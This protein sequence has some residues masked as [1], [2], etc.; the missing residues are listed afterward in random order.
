MLDTTPA[1]WP[2]AL[3]IGAPTA[4]ILSLIT[5]RIYRR[6][7]MRRMA[8]A[9]GKPSTIA[10]DASLPAEREAAIEFE[11]LDPTNQSFAGSPG[12]REYRAL[13]RRTWAAAT[14]YVVA[15]AL[16]TLIDT[17]VGQA[18]F[19]E[20][21]GLDPSGWM[22]GSGWLLA[23]VFGLVAAA[24]RAEAARIAAIYCVLTLASVTALSATQPNVYFA[25]ILADWLVEMLGTLILILAFLNRFVRAVGPLLLPLTILS[26]AGA[27]QAFVAVSSIL[28]SVDIESIESWTI[29]QIVVVSVFTR[30]GANGY[31]IVVHLAGAIVSFSLGWIFLRWLGRQY[32]RR[33]FSAETLT[34]DAIFLSLTWMHLAVFETANWP[35]KFVPLAAFAAYMIASRTGF[36]IARRSVAPPEPT[37]TLLLLRVFSLG[38]R[39]E[40]L[41]DALSKRWLRIGAIRMISGPDLAKRAV[42][43]HEFL[44]FLSGRLSDRFVRDDKDL[45]RRV[46]RLDPNP[47]P[48]GRYRITEFYCRTDNW[49]GTVARLALEND[50][51]VMDLRGFSS[52]ND[53]CRY[54]LSMLVRTDSLSRAT[55]IVDAT[56]DMTYLEQVLRDAVGASAGLSPSG[57]SVVPAARLFKLEKISP[58]TLSVLIKSLL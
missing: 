37:R 55:L 34:I 39:S 43:P 38:A 57:D 13:M 41:F 51:I 20:L 17:L 7:V 30:L 46:A 19:P 53:G 47:D 25:D 14:V 11:V 8:G 29:S 31:A 21:G 50:V 36:R 4:V 22:A 58:L 35:T 28:F 12:D 9:S 6:S 40:K 1:L 32:E 26:V 2:M 48:D 49:R 54:E 15:G 44:A 45:E 42:Q 52:V 27:L 24:T 10:D 56:T 3:S 33:R 5:L 18:V 23:L 16:F